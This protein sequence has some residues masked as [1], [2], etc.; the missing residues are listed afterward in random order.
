MSDSHTK[1][2]WISSSGLGGN[3]ITDGRTHGQM[4]RSDITISTLLFC[5]CFQKERVDKHK[6]PPKLFFIIISYICF[7]NILYYTKSAV[8]WCMTRDTSSQETLRISSSLWI[9]PCIRGKPLTPKWVILQTAEA[10]KKCRN[11]RSYI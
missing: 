1:F 3:C 11:M 7:L 10:Q 5:F 2:V 4:D 8:K 9:N 6:M